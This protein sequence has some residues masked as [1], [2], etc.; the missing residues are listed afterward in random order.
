M[1][2]IPLTAQL[3]EENGPRTESYSLLPARIRIKWIA[4]TVLSLTKKNNN[5]R[6]LQTVMSRPNLSHIITLWKILLVV[7]PVFVLFLPCPRNG[8][9]C[10][11]VKILIFP[12]SPSCPATQFWPMTC[13]QSLQCGASDENGLR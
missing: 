9:Q 10:V 4:L 13:K 7:S 8:W 3:Y 11:H 12:D 2:L 6:R 5:L 1:T